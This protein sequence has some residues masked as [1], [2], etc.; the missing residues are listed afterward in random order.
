MIADVAGMLTAVIRQARAARTT[1][2]RFTDSQPGA[3]A[4]SGFTRQRK[5]PGTIACRRALH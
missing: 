1:A 4:T 2:V 5:D 3:F